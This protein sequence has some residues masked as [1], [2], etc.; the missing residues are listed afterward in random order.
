MECCKLA[1]AKK[2]AKAAKTVGQ[3]DTTGIP[4]KLVQ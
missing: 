3:L 4:E 2:D 1:A